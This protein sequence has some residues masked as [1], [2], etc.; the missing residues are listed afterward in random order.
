MCGIM[1]LKNKCKFW[2]SAICVLKFKI[3]GQSQMKL[4]IPHTVTSSF[5]KDTKW[6]FFLLILSLTKSTLILKSVRL[7]CR[8]YLLPSCLTSL[9]FPCSSLVPK[10][11]EITVHFSSLRSNSRT[12]FWLC[13]VSS[14]S[15]CY[16]NAVFWQG[17]LIMIQKVSLP[18][19]TRT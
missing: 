2:I 10:I 12:L 19:C 14:F 5:L 13:P 16:F 4:T 17:L 8:L 3:K 15:C 1:P 11:P 18:A 9:L 7:T 6:G